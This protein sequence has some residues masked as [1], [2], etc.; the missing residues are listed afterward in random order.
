[1]WTS[2][3]AAAGGLVQTKSG[4]IA[5]KLNKLTGVERVIGHIGSIVPHLVG[6]VVPQITHIVIIGGKAVNL[7]LGAVKYGG[8]K[9][10]KYLQ[11]QGIQKIANFATDD[12]FRQIV[13]QVALYLTLCIH[14]YLENFKPKDNNYLEKVDKKEIKNLAKFASLRIFQHLMRNKIDD[15]NP[16]ENLPRALYKS[17]GVLSKEDKNQKKKEKKSQ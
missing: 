5:G 10:D 16:V 14:G 11:E 15:E 8:L 3:R 17:V 2:Y 4:W 6:V 12:E 13:N 9:L 1:M 7:T